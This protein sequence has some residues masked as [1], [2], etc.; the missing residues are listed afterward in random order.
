MLHNL[1]DLLGGDGCCIVLRN[2]WEVMLHSLV[3]LLGG[4]AAYFGGPNGR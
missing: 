2:Y 4:D 1:E 3:D